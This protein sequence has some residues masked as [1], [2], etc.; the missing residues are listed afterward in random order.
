MFLGH[1]ADFD[2]KFTNQLFADV[3]LPPLNKH[4]VI[5][6]TSS[7]GFITLGLYKSDMLFERLGF[8]KR[9]AHNALEDILMTL[10]TCK[11]IKG[12]MA[13]AMQEIYG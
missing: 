2:I 7:T 12:L 8:D 4:H 3:G 9:G 1:N 5:L 13:F 11:I 10:E 6:D